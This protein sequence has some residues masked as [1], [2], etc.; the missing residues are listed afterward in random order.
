MNFVWI[1]VTF[2]RPLL[3]TH[4]SLLSISNLCAI[5]AHAL[6]KIQAIDY[7]SSP[8]YTLHLQIQ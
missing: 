8:S 3:L 7:K 5:T 4:L 2:R 6:E 1:L